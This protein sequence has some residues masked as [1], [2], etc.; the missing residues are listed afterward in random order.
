MPHIDM[1]WAHS[2]KSYILMFDLAGVDLERPIIDVA[3]GASSFNFEMKRQGYNVISCDPLYSLSTEE[4][5]VVVHRHVKHLI[6]RV[7]Q[8]PAS[9]HWGQEYSN[10]SEL[11]RQQTAMAEIFL[12]DYPQGIEENR[13]IAGS[14]PSLNFMDYQ[15]SLAL[16]ANFLMEGA[17]ANDLE[18]QL[19]AIREMCRIAQEVRIYPLLNQQG[20]ISPHLGPIIAALQAEDYGV[21]VRE[22]PYQFIKQGNAML[23]VFL[24]NCPFNIQK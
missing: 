5:T 22:V 12:N 23:R 10:L 18:F 17:Y 11:E 6:E 9:F 24:R 1:S 8:S 20:E 14:L 19:H 2:L 16:C 13:Y 4:I 3:A 7:K 21:E 15:F